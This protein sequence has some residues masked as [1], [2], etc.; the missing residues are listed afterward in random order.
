M[1]FKNSGEAA[2][3]FWDYFYVTHYPADNE[4][5]VWRRIE[6]ATIRIR[7][8]EPYLAEKYPAPVRFANG[9]RIR[10]AAREI[11]RLVDKLE[12]VVEPWVGEMVGSLEVLAEL[13]IEVSQEEASELPLH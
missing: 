12:S 6:C 4:A 2:L 13:V 3:Y 5:K 7:E 10:R 1:R 8:S 9:K 11:V